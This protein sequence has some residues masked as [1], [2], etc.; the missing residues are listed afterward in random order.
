MRASMT[1]VRATEIAG[2]DCARQ[3]GEPEHAWGSGHCCRRAADA[4]REQ[5]GG[6]LIRISLR[7]SAPNLRPRIRLSAGNATQEGT[8]PD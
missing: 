5:S 1:I 7:R 8:L 3:R 4:R 2:V 6:P